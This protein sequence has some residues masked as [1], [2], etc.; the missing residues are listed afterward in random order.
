MQPLCFTTFRLTQW[1]QQYPTIAW[2]LAG[3]FV[4]Q[5]FRVTPFLCVG[6]TKGATAADVVNLTRCKRG[7]LHR[8]LEAILT[9]KFV[10]RKTS[11]ANGLMVCVGSFSSLKWLNTQIILAVLRH[12]HTAGRELTL[13]QQITVSFQCPVPRRGV[14]VLDGISNVSVELARIRTPVPW[15]QTV[16]FF[17]VISS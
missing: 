1:S 15:K 9:V 12:W 14:G 13:Q 6:S 8:F 2:G 10:V 16:I 5:S 4:G 11:Y 17:P 3:R 7:C